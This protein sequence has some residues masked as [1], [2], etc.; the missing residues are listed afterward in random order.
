MCSRDGIL[1]SRGKG[2]T[3][4]YWDIALTLKLG[5]TTLFFSCKLFQIRRD[6]YN[7]GSQHLLS[8]AYLPKQKLLAHAVTT[9]DLLE[10]MFL[11]LKQT[12]PPVRHG[13]K[14]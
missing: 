7:L 11:G 9:E 12:P 6:A 13:F 2:A 4:S 1:L 3:F 8:S 10:N 14:N 5:V